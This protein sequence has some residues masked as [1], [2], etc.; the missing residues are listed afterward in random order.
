MEIVTLFFPPT[1]FKG[2]YFWLSSEQLEGQFS[3]PVLSKLPFGKASNV[4]YCKS[5][6]NI[7]FVCLFIIFWT[8]KMVHN[9]YNKNYSFV[10]GALK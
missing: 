8:G 7:K 10:Y 1:Q 4:Y 5:I 3:F 6:L 2:I 9:S